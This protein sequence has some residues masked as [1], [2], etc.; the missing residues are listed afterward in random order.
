MVIVRLV[1]NFHLN[2]ISESVEIKEQLMA[3]NA[4]GWVNVLS[5]YFNYPLEAEEVASEDD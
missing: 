5:F 3:L 1:A 4:M 2:V